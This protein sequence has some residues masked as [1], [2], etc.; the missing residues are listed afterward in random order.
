MTIYEFLNSAE[1]A[2]MGWGNSV[3]RANRLYNR[4]LSEEIKSKLI[5]TSDSYQETR[6]WL[7]L[8]YGS[9]SRIICD[10][11]NDLATRPKPGA[12]DSNARFSFFS[13]I[14]GALQCV[15]RLTKIVEI[16]KQELENC[17]YSQATLNSLFLILP[18][19]TH[20]NWITKMMESG[21]DYKNP[22]GAE[23][24][25]V[26]KN[27]CIIERNAS[28]GS[29]IPDKVSSPRSK[30]RSAFKVQESKDESSVDEVG[31]FASFHNKKW[32]SN[33]LKFPCPIGNYQH[34]LNTCAEFF[35]MSPVERW[36]KMD[37]GKLCYSCLDKFEI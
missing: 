34:E 6:Q 23:A 28:E 22:T 25:T 24:Y 4:H 12:N 14:S 29:R 7:I 8:Q 18:H 21:L 5:N 36:N 19:K 16:N 9:A 27:L 32:Y 33:H 13:H 20:M 1:I 26:F 10:I 15:E 2:Y 17:L 35:S 30:S 37:K 31:V 3:Q 11:I